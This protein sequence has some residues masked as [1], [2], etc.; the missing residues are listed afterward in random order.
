MAV[1]ARMNRCETARRLESWRF[2]SDWLR[3]DRLVGGDRT[4]GV[5]RRAAP[6]SRTPA[7][8]QR[9][10]QGRHRDQAHSQAAKTLRSPAI[11]L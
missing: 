7:P 8:R 3:G 10:R 1:P 5:P 2:A 6:A 9:W 11:R 4:F